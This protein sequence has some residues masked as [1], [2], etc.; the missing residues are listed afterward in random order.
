MISAF[1]VYVIILPIKESWLCL[2]TIQ[3]YSGIEMISLFHFFSS[4]K[5]FQHKLTILK[6]DRLQ[7]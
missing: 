1:S 3:P 6:F 2:M 5:A 7:E 4:Y